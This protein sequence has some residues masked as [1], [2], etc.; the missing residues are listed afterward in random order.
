MKRQALGKGLDA[1]LPQHS[2][3]S[4]SSLLLL[5]LE[6]VRPNALQPRARFDPDKLEELAA[7]IRENGVLQPVIVRQSGGGYELIA[8]ERRW[9]AAQKAGLARIPALVQQASDEKMLELALV[10]NLQRDELNPLEEAHAYQLLLEQFRLTQEEVAR[11]VGRSRAAVT[12]TL[13]LLRLPR[14]V[15]QALLDGQLSMGHARALV[16]LPQ[17]LQLDLARDIARQGLSVRDVERKARR[18][19]QPLPAGRKLKDAN[20]RAAEQQLET[21]WKTRVE[22]RKQGARGHVA[23][24]FDSEQELQRLYARL[25]EPEDEGKR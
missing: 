8:G 2:A 22:I 14:P 13:R 11:R 9:R 20:L 17:R 19:L 5:E 21:H 4:S 15:Q 12:N 1:L 10:E 3:A 25:L 23:L 16:P 24:F 6:A 18:A 7:S